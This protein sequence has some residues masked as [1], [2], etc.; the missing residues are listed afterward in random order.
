MKKFFIWLILAGILLTMVVQGMDA[1]MG[2]SEK[3]IRTLGFKNSIS[4][5]AMKIYETAN[6]LY[7]VSVYG[8]KVA[9]SEEVSLG[10][11][12]TMEIKEYSNGEIINYGKT[13]YEEYRPSVGSK[14]TVWESWP[15]DGSPVIIDSSKG[16]IY[17]GDSNCMFPKTYGDEV[18]FFEEGSS[19]HI[20]YMSPGKNPVKINTNSTAV[21]ET[22]EK[23]YGQR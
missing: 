1:T 2:H 21:A 11:S 15:E 12:T 6:N 13:G 18:A 17:H 3:N 9:W 7:D 22:L 20:V 10:N 19:P 14:Y 5:D 23:A 4:L 8:E 16:R